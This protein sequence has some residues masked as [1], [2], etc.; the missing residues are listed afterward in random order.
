M[1][2]VELKWKTGLYL[3]MGVLKAKLTL[4]RR[5]LI[6]LPVPLLVIQVG[7][8]CSAGT[9]GPSAGMDQECGCCSSTSLLQCWE[10]L[11]SGAEDEVLSQHHQTEMCFQAHKGETGIQAI[12]PCSAEPFSSQR[13]WTDQN[14]ILMLLQDEPFPCF[15]WNKK[16]QFNHPHSFWHRVSSPQLSE[17]HFQVCNSD[18]GLIICSEANINWCNAG[19]FNNWVSQQ[20]GNTLLLTTLVTKTALQTRCSCRDFVL[21]SFTLFLDSS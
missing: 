17:R 4:L 13:W 5:S 16:T 20:T 6:Y 10:P 8:L 21:P 1:F 18:S 14:Q 7:I 9:L 3:S 2:S 19:S 12:P 15:N 11:Q